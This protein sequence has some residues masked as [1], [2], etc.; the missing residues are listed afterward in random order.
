M[1]DKLD[2]NEYLVYDEIS[3][4][5]VVTCFLSHKEKSSNTYM[6]FADTET[7]K[8]FCDKLNQMMKG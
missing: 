2:S 4:A 7:A 3:K 6:K 8:E 5:F 1:R